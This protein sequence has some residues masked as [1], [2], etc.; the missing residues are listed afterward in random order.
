MSAHLHIPQVLFLVI[1]QRQGGA[2]LS[3]CTATLPF[4][5]QTGFNALFTSPKLLFPWLTSST[6][7]DK[8][9]R[10]TMSCF[11]TRPQIEMMKLVILFTSCSQAF[12]TSFVG[13]KTTGVSFC[14]RQHNYAD[15]QQQ[16][17]G[18]ST[19]KNIY[20]ALRSFNIGYIN[21]S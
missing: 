12:R 9:I 2:E 4:P 10:F 14:E 18:V 3:T 16:G 7:Q 11:L 15:L 1:Q 8:E 20:F 19:T 6:F 17:S 21:S 13:F 5:P